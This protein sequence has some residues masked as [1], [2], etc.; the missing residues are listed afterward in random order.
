MD[1]TKHLACYAILISVVFLAL[2]AQAQAQFN[3]VRG[4]PVTVTTS[5]TNYAITIQQ[6]IWNVVCVSSLGTDDWDIAHGS[7][8]STW[9]SNFADFVLADGSQTPITGNA[10]TVTMFSGSQG[11][12]L[13][14]SNMGTAMV[15]GSTRSFSWG[16]NNIVYYWEIQ[17]AQG[18]NYNLTVTGNT[19]MWYDLFAPQ[20]TSAWIGS[21]QNMLA[22][23][24]GT[25]SNNIGLAPG[26][27]CL[28][29]SLGGGGGITSN[30]Q[31]S[32]NW[33]G[34]PNLQAT[35]VSVPGAP[36]LVSPTGTFQ[37]SRTITNAGTAAG[38]TSYTIYLS[39]DTNITTAD[40]AVYTGMS[41]LINP[42]GVDTANSVCTVPGGTTPGSYYAGLFINT[43]N[44]ANTASQDVI[45]TT[46]FTPVAQSVSVVGAP[47]TVMTGGTFQVTRSIQNTGGIAGST[48]Y[49]IYL[50][51]DNTITGADTLVYSGTT[52]SIAPGGTDTG[53]D[54]CTVPGS[55]SAGVY[56]AGLWVSAGNSA[57]TASADV[58]VQLPP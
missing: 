49:S 57:C 56:Y 41:N 37:V 21:P 30:I 1:R 32:I 54:T 26:T 4:T 34:T 10:G 19:S 9:G 58:T 42:S 51:P 27:H 14:H 35:S 40:I 38:S 25:P 6:G 31:V 3:L 36:V 12:V 5:P 33:S 48:T 52:A 55:M 39:T 47:V 46:P 43:S 22:Q 15:P 18:G 28:V 45:V 8:S 29:V 2:T 50:S 24:V 23:W 20:S 53:T 17:I 11:A 16:M 7:G 44:T 13:E